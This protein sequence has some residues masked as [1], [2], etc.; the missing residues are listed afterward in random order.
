MLCNKG[1]R[2]LLLRCEHGSKSTKRVAQ[3]SSHVHHVF[4]VNVKLE[5]SLAD[6]NEFQSKYKEYIA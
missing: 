4:D 1:K 5:D 3:E 2:A 6:L